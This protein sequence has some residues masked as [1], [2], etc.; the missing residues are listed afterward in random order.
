MSRFE[1]RLG[2]KS[3]SP[4][5]GQAV[6]KIPKK[7][8]NV[9]SGFINI[10]EKNTNSQNTQ[11]SNSQNTRLSNSQNTR[12]SNNQEN[13]IFVE[14]V[15]EEEEDSR[16]KKIMTVNEQLKKAMENIRDKNIRLIYGHEIRLNTVE[17]NI[18][19]LNDIKCSTILNEQQEEEKEQQVMHNS[20]KIITI[21][22]NINNNSISL[23]ESIIK[24]HTNLESLENNFKAQNNIINE[25]ILENKEKEIKQQQIEDN[26]ND[27]KSLMKKYDD[28]IYKFK[29]HMQNYKSKINKEKKEKKELK[30]EK[31]MILNILKKV[32]LKVEDNDEII[33]EID[34]LKLI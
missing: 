4:R 31:E 7:N 21:E 25:I 18:D 33:K 32:A 28:F 30:K 1:R 6:C 12:L 3:S 34:E 24:I 29:T 15:M 17:L 2:A 8:N 19:C 20:K 27:I 14:E 22:E 13:K 16:I 11:L 23:N 10:Q 26:L 9:L 5:P